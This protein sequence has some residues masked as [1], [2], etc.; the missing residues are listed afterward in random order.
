MSNWTADDV[1]DLSG[2]TIVVTG[3]NSGLGFEATRVFVRKGATVVMACRST[4]RGERAATEIR[5]LEGF[6]TDESVLDV[7]ECDLGDLASVESFADDLLADYEG[8][9]VLCNNAGV[10]AIPRSETADGFETQFGVNHLGHFALTGHLLDR[11]VATPGETR[12]V[13][14]SSGAH[15]GGEIDFDDLHH[16]DSYGKWEAYGQSKLANLLFA[17]EL[18]RRL[19]AAGIDDTVSAACHPGYADTSLQAR[20]PKEEGSTVKLYAMRAANAVLGQSAEMGA[21]PLVHA[22]TAPGVD[23]G[24]Y[25]GPGGLFDMRGYPEP[26]RSNDRSYDEDIADRL[27]TVSEDLTGVTYDFDALADAGTAGEAGDET[28][29]EA[30]SAAD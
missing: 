4:D 10:M 24:S 11:I 5:Q 8:I 3:A 25:I 14:H 27:W 20:G 21:L 12:V 9:H 17:Y 6:P 2:Q 13:S 26:Q 30:A 18:Q 23:G 22:A 29:D 19:S 7:R 16:E 1:P 28:G 15:Q